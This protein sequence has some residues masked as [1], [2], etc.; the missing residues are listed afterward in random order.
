MKFIVNGFLCLLFL[1]L[2]PDKGF[3]F[4]VEPGR[5]YRKVKIGE[6]VTGQYLLLNNEGVALRF[7]VTLKGGTD[8]FRFSGTD[9][10][11]KPNESKILPYEIQVTRTNLK[12]EQQAGLT[13]SQVPLEQDNRGNPGASFQTRIT[14]PV[15]CLVEG[16]EK[17]D[18][19]IEDL[20]LNCDLIRKEKEI[21]GSLSAR[22]NIRN[23]GNLHFLCE[24]RL[25]V[26]RISAN[27]KKELIAERPAAKTILLFPGEKE[28]LRME[29]PGTWEAGDYS[30]RV[31][32]YFKFD[33]DLHVDSDDFLK[34][35]KVFNKTKRF[36]VDADG[37]VLIEK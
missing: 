25:F 26:Y 34:E 37:N 19:S 17:M 21:N 30:A 8:W 28:V 16:T 11:L 33:E 13:V 10:V 20:D 24:A 18:Y 5:V 36:R 23:T 35:E 32:L 27:N 29:Y 3:S 6:K 22:V 31:F 9:L 1:V 2:G 14:L 15:Y 7:F 12:G 4:S